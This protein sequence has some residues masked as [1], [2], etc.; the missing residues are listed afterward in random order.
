MIKFSL[1][2]KETTSMI[3]EVCIKKRPP[4]ER[5]LSG[6]SP[7]KRRE[8]SDHE[9]KRKESMQR[10]VEISHILWSIIIPVCEFDGAFRSGAWIGDPRHDDR[11]ELVAAIGE[12][13]FPLRRLILRL[14]PIEVGGLVGVAMSGAMTIARCQ[15]VTD[16]NPYRC[17]LEFI[18]DV[19]SRRGHFPFIRMLAERFLIELDKYRAHNIF[20]KPLRRCCA[21]GRVDCM[22]WIM[23]SAHTRG[24]AYPHYT[25]YMITLHKM[26]RSGNVDHCARFID[27]FGAV[28]NEGCTVVDS[29]RDHVV[30]AFQSGYID[31]ARWALGR[32][33][34]ERRPNENHATLVESYSKL[35]RSGKVDIAGLI[36]DEVK[37]PEGIEIPK[38]D[39]FASGCEIDSHGTLLV[40]LAR[41]L[42]M[43]P[44]DIII[45]IMKI[46]DALDLIARK[47]GS[48]IVTNIKDVLHAGQCSSKSMG[49]LCPD[50]VLWTMTITAK[51]LIVPP[52][53][54]EVID[55]FYSFRMANRQI[56]ANN[57]CIGCIS[58]EEIKC[59]KMVRAAEVILKYLPNEQGYVGWQL[60][61]ASHRIR[62]ELLILRCLEQKAYLTLMA[63]SAH[64]IPC[65]SRLKEI[66]IDIVCEMDPA[67]LAPFAISFKASRIIYAMRN[68][69][70]FLYSLKDGPESKSARII[71]DHFFRDGE[72]PSRE[73]GKYGRYTTARRTFNSRRGCWELDRREIVD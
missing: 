58:D 15:I 13:F 43:K 34:F 60:Y 68:I 70:H 18:I 27:A 46:D 28:M 53:A 1:H 71:S 48:S 12:T 55:A 10:I 22:E 36:I 6:V 38:T 9:E 4:A 26:M 56:H 29:N 14:I 20:S 16:P 7:L 21:R 31:V 57:P 64:Y 65:N 8:M 66:I 35:F 62:Y 32:F 11:F 24:I 72:M 42:C 49:I 2:S 73:F 30:H 47:S 17:F 39:V 19:A 59:A 54:M 45:A 3:A 37:L 25:D 50:V 67:E 69:I 5:E 33:G 44:I 40:W 51:E 23:E 61:Y 41:R 52:D 63:C